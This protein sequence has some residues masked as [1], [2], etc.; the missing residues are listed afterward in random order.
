MVENAIQTS[1]IQIPGTE[2]GETGDKYY[3]HVDGAWIPFMSERTKKRLGK[4]FHTT[5][6]DKGAVQSKQA[7]LKAWRLAVG[8]SGLPG[9]FKVWI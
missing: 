8:N 6:S 9:K 2:V 7:E 4:I 1:Y 3:F 5:L